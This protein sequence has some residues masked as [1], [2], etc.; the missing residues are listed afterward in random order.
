MAF[1][2]F[3]N[4]R[5]AGLSAG[6]PKEIHLTE[7]EENLSDDYNAASFSESTG[8]YKRR[9]SDSLTLSD[10]CFAAA[11]KLMLD[12]EWS[13]DTIDA[14]IV[15]TQTPD[16][17]A[18]A[19][20]CILQY[21]LGLNKECYA[22]DISLGCSGWVYGLSVVAGLL[23]NGCM[24]RALLLAGD[25]RQWHNEKIDALFGS[26]GTVTAI[27]YN[28]GSSFR[29]HFGTD[30][31]GWDALYVPDG[32]ARNP[33]SAKSLEYENIDGKMMT[34]LQSRML[35]MDVFSFGITTAPKSVKKIL[36]HNGMDINQIDYYVFH[37]AN[38]L[39][40]DTIIK[41]LKLEKEKVP[42]CMDEF[43]N[44]S[45]ASIPLTIVTRMNREMFANKT[46]LCSG[47]GIGLSWGSVIVHIDNIVISKLVEVEVENEL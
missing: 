42:L 24:K 46:L 40:I 5:I 28:E 26:A 6:V 19:T 32:G 20:A 29:F 43:G 34:R 23:S 35:G 1:L 9:Y 8:V 37:Q 16:Y 2:E 10:L 25:A 47:F 11:K 45:S 44:T 36:E 39:M 33:I 22:L 13:S 12:L 15:V 18:P 4:V 30:G 41:K 27:E 38:K 14:I 17:I 31:S 21:K 3:K 7:Q